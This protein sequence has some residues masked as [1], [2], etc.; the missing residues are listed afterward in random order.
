M[1]ACYMFN[2]C[3]AIL[4]TMWCCLLCLMCDE[5]MAYGQVSDAKLILSTLIMGMK[6]LLYSITNYGNTLPSLSPPGTPQLVRL[7]PSNPNAD[8]RMHP[9]CARPR[10]GVDANCS[11]SPCFRSALF[12]GLAAAFVP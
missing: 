7:L 2:P 9:V 12:C 6:T 5:G 3:L 10:R 8:T 11:L 4:I 1:H